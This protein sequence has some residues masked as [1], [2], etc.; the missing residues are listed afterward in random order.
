[1]ANE[2]LDNNERIHLIE[3]LNV[4]DFHNFM[5]R[6]YL[7]MTDGGGIQ[8]DATSLGI[9]VLVLRDT[10]KRHEGIK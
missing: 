7:I 9:P 5:S 4:V 2:I 1:M 6:T 10:M 3:P 8:E